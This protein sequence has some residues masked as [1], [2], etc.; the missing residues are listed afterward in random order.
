MSNFNQ[1]S[2]HITRSPKLHLIKNSNVTRWNILP[3]TNKH[4]LEHGDYKEEQ[5]LGN[6]GGAKIG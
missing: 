3:A 6:L 5:S 4:W 1:K 2:K